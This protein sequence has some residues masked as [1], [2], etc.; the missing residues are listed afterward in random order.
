MV[1]V[2]RE[3]YPT[4]LPVRLVDKAPHKVIIMDEV[5][6]MSAGDRGG[7]AELIQLIKKTAAPIICICNDHSSPK[8]RTLAGHCLDLKFRR[9]VWFIWQSVTPFLTY[10][11]LF[12]ILQSHRC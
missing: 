5:D 1:T 2:A 4:N 10:H 12:K 6:G 11:S 9:C 8:M 7:S 3:F